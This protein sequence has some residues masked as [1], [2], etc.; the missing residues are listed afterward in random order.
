MGKR[1]N[2][3][4]IPQDAYQTI[5]PKARSNRGAGK[6]LRFLR[7]A[8]S[9]NGDACLL[10]PYYR[11]KNGYGHVGRH[12]GMHLAHRLMCEMAHGPAPFEGAQA[13]HKCGN[14]ACVN[15]GHIRWGTQKDN[16]DDKLDH[17]TWFTR[18]GGAKLTE[19]RVVAIRNAATA[20]ATYDELATQFETP[21]STIQKV[22]KRYTWKHVGGGH[23]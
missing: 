16:E 21:K 3:S 15:P 18:F 14:R 20:G 1:S 8:L 9:Y 4:R 7:Q 5:D 10:W 23:V 12:D 22:V 2:F 19:E 17:G 13:T 11:M 6:G